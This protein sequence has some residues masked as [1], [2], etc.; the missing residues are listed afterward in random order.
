VTPRGSVVI[1]LALI[2]LAIAP[3][4]AQQPPAGASAVPPATTPQAG[5]AP[6]QPGAQPSAPGYTYD[7]EG[8]RDPF[9]SLL[10]RATDQHRPGGKP[11]EGVGGFL[12][13]E[14]QLKGVMQSRG[15]YLALVLGPDNK[16][17]TVRVNDRLLDGSV[18][19]ITS[20]TL[21][22]MQDVNDPLSLTKQ[23]EVRKTLRVA[24]EVK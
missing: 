4:F 16:T 24:V 7:P 2:A 22:L 6:A 5:Q 15:A 10:R 9:V 17:Y 20:D 12:V 21:V 18:R 19:A 1:A 3:G 23:R 8:R 11:A 13:S 14:I